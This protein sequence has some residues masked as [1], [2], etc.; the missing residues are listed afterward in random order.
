MVYTHT[1]SRANS[2]GWYKE[3]E[4]GKRGAIFSTAAQIATI[5]SGVLQS[6][7]GSGDQSSKIFSDALSDQSTPTW[8][9]FKGSQDISGCQSPL[10]FVRIQR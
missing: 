2:L 5:F 6:T 10:A 1:F 9:A 7:S 8:T 4:L 3:S